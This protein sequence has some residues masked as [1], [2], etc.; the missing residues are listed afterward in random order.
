MAGVG[1]DLTSR[2]RAWFIEQYRNGAHVPILK[3]VAAGGRPEDLLRTMS[4]YPLVVELL[5]RS[6]KALE[7]F[8]AIDDRRGAMS[9]IISMAYMTWAPDMH[10]GASPARR[11]EEIRNLATRLRSLSLESERAA[12]EAQMVYG[13]HV[14]CRSKVIPDLALARGR[15]AYGLA[16][17]IGD[18]ALEFL[19]AL[20]TA[21]ASLEV[22][23]REGASSWIDCAAA[24][25]TASPTPTRGRALEVARGRCAA[26]N[27]DA[28]GLHAHMQQA[29]EQTSGQDRRAARCE[30]LA[31]YALECVWLTRERGRPSRTSHERSSTSPMLERSRRC[32]SWPSSPDIRRG[33][34]MRRRRGPRSRYRAVTRLR[35]SNSP[36]PP[37]R[38]PRRP[39]ARTSTSRPHPAARVVLAVGDPA[40]QAAFETCCNSCRA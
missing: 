12:A 19:T 35:R 24:V 25:A 4:V 39:H 36:G 5:R 14:Y 29:L 32:A 31:A 34:G 40:E 37:S 28:D 10:L 8:E 38:D 23:D 13:V 6:Q 1:R 15:E 22:G 33:A 21:E 9:T 27:S 7:L 17:T 16:R 3:H 26:A 18:R 30:I 2:A 11:I 20:G